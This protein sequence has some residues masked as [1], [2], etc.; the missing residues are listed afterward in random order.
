MTWDLITCEEI[1]TETDRQTDGR[2]DLTTP[3]ENNNEE[4]EETNLRDRACARTG[5]N[6]ACREVHLEAMFYMLY[7]HTYRQYRHH[8]IYMHTHIHTHAARE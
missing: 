5:N 6:Q 7:I 8:I 2:D 3:A 1:R 4:E